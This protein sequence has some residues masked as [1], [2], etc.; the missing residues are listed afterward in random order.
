MNIAI[1]FVDHLQQ[2]IITRFDAENRIGK[3][4]FILVPAAIIKEIN[5]NDLAC[6]LQFWELDMPSHSSQLS[7][8][9]LWK[10][11]WKEHELTRQYSQLSHRSW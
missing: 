4:T 8:L 5:S 7:D 11:F 1:P 3:D 10:K 2:E 6:R 9:K